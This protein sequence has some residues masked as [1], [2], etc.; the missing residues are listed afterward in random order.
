[1]MDFLAAA[2]LGLIVFAAIT[3]FYHH[4]L[5]RWINS[6]S[7]RQ[8]VLGGLLGIGTVQLMLQ[9]VEVAP[10]LLIDARVLLMG[11]AGLLAGWRGAA[12]A[13][14]VAIPAR[15]LMGGQGVWIGCLT[16][17][18]APL[19]GLVWSWIQERLEISNS[20][21]HLAFGLMLSGAL[22]TILL[23]PEAQRELVIQEAIHLLVA[24]NVLGAFWAGWLEIGIG[25][26]AALRERLRKR[27]LTDDLTGLGNRLSLTETLDATLGNRPRYD[28]SIALIS[29][30]IDN[31][32]NVNDTLGHKVGDS[33]LI[34]IANRL[35]DL[36]GPKDALTRVAGDQFVVIKYGASESEVIAHAKRILE[37]SRLPYRVDDFGIL[38][39]ASVGIVWA[40]ENGSDPIRLLQNVDIATQQSKIKGRNQFTC[41]QKHMRHDLERSVN[42]SQALPKSL[43]SQEGLALEFQPQICMKTQRVCAA[44][45]L[46][47]WEHP[48]FGVVSP[49]EFIPIGESSGLARI[50][51][52]VVLDLAAQQLSKWLEQGVTLRLAINVS[53][54]TLQL[55]GAHAQIISKLRSHN[56]PSHLVEI[57]VTET[58]HLENSDEVITNIVGLREHGLTVALDDFGTGHASLSYLQKLPVDLIKIDRSFIQQIDKSGGGSNAIINA[59][60]AMAEALNLTVVAE[61]VETEHQYMWLAQRGCHLIQG[62]YVGKP[63]P[64]DIFMQSYGQQL[65]S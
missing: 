36:M 20:W 56:I 8:L 60:L 38:I 4:Y 58:Y 65:Q 47:R 28:K 11:F 44:E 39:T 31:F 62:Y 57:E 13:L 63:A 50:I 6:A 14:M 23:F 49:A 37:M 5:T 35:R 27:S 24:I 53:V 40:P 22:V 18:L 51:D 3:L 29:I 21:R 30:D 43:K 45:V 25:N 26:A 32:K 55:E 2:S 15:I 34:E 12:A 64:H 16:L 7:N 54:L 61:G 19:I 52:L 42:I 9:P 33:F 46:L 41:F 10:G 1:M 17:S 48:E 59:I